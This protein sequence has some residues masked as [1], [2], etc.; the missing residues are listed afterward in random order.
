MDSILLKQKFRKFFIYR[1]EVNYYIICTTKNQN[2]TKI[3]II[4]RLNATLDLT[5]Q[6]ATFTLEEAMRFV[7]KALPPPPPSFSD[8]PKKV[9]SILMAYF[10]A[11]SYGLIGFPKF[12]DGP[13]IYF[14]TKRQKM[15]R[16]FG[17]DVYKIE[18]AKLEMVLNQDQSCLYKITN[19]KTSEIKYLEYFNSIDNRDFYFSYEIDL[20][21]RAQNFWA[22]TPKQDS[23]YIWNSAILESFYD[24]VPNDEFILPIICGYI[25]IQP[26][27]IGIKDIK[28]AIVSRR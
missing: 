3:I 11:K 28:I 23:R 17:S 26:F 19:V 2:L 5:I 24:L 20:T 13:Y 18:E 7:A 6:T 9:S 1:N 15:G 10:V 22:G 21:N 25:E 8:P 12:L 27:K 4:S 14:I 16:I